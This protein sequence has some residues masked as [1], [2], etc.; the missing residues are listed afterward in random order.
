[1]ALSSPG[2]EKNAKSLVRK[3]PFYG[4]R[5]ERRGAEAKK[6]GTVLGGACQ[7]CGGAPHRDPK[8]P[9]GS[10][11]KE[12]GG[13]EIVRTAGWEKAGKRASLN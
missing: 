12:A 6:K 8:K 10:K 5:K 2:K 11:K 9:D 1:V 3:D 7:G 13:K 4:G